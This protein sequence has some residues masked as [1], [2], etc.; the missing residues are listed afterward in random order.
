MH[1]G[2]RFPSAYCTQK[3]IRLEP[4]GVLLQQKAT[5]IPFTEDFKPAI[6]P[7]LALVLSLMKWGQ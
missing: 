4:V 2:Q 5:G 1:K 3:A 6:T 7:L